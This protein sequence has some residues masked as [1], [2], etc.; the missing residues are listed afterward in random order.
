M[1]AKTQQNY[2]PTPDATKAEGIKYDELYPKAFSLPATYIRFSST[3]E[4][5]IGVSYCLNED[6]AEFLADLND[7]KDINGQP[8][9]DKSSQCTE[10]VFEEVMN[11]F[12]ETSQRVQPFA[13][14]DSPPLLSLEEM[15]RARDENLS[16]EA[17]KFFKPIY[18]YWLSK[19]GSRLLMPTI[20]VRVL[21]TTNEADDADP[22]VCFRRREVRQTRKTRGRDAQV[23]EKLKKLRLELEQAR[24]LV[25]LVKER[26]ELNKQ[27]LEISR[28]VFEQ[29]RQLKEVK[30]TKNIIGEKGDD[31]ELLVNQ[32]VSLPVMS[33]TLIDLADVYSAGTQAQGKTRR[34]STAPNYPSITLRWRRSS[35]LRKRSYPAF[36]RPVSGRGAYPSYH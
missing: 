17:Q 34:Q 18:Q 8:I 30:T 35:G 13:N 20:K 23:V 9:K 25:Q 7:G 22:Y 29:R 28:K 14:V 16:S 6:D 21:D 24:Q 33:L 15:E 2:I 1:G 26:E 4:D 5:C 36:R 19:K 3:V 12:E 11:Y 31:E 10:D 27:N 32:K